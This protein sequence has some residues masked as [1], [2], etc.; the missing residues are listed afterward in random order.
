[1]PIPNNNPS[2]ANVSPGHY[3]SNKDRGYGKLD[4]V[5]DKPRSRGHALH[6]PRGPYDDSEVDPEEDVD[7]ED[8]KFHNKIKTS[9]KYHPNDAHAFKSRDMFSFN[10]L[11]N[12]VHESNSIIE[13]YIKE[14][15]ISE[16]SGRRHTLGTIGDPYKKDTTSLGSMG[17]TNAGYIDHD[18]ITKGYHDTDG[19]GSIIKPDIDEPYNEDETSYEY[20]LRTSNEDF[21]YANNHIA[22]K[23][24]KP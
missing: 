3:D 9:L 10:G 7:I 23:N 14:V 11:A 13:S 4:I 1:M 6:N 16:I 18:G 20:F 15:L 12:T 22:F 19:A 24:K 17:M 2:V 5:N 21:V 8:I